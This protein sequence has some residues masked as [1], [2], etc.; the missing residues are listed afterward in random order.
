MLPSPGVGTGSL[1]GKG[2]VQGTKEAG[3]RAGTR[4]QLEPR[5][6]AGALPPQTPRWRAFLPEALPMEA[7]N[8]F[9]KS[10]D[11]PVKTSGEH[12]LHLG[13]VKR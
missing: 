10:P 6:E 1:G 12:I 5:P 11:V 9:L 13:L 8:H 3:G 4:P 7:A 2:L